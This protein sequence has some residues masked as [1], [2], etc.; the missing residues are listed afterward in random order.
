MRI[1][2]IDPGT[3]TTGYSIIENING[4]VK[5]LDYGCIRTAAGL[6]ANIRLNQIAEDI[7]TL[8]KKWQPQHASVE[9]LYFKKNVKTAIDVA[10]ARGVIIQKLTEGGVEFNEYTPLEIKL[11][12]CGYG[13]ADKKMVQQMVKITL[14]MTETPKPDDAADAIA[15]AIC[16][17]NSI[18]LKQKISQ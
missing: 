11:A 12:I 9:K 6:G 2:G 18:S 13:K 16:L 14:G 5:V 17:A 15:A 1:I 4:K 7:E 10:Q 3:A 8:V